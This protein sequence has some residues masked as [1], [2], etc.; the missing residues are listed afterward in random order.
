MKRNVEQVWV[1]R[2]TLGA[3]YK[4]GALYLSKNTVFSPV[5]FL[6]VYSEYEGNIFPHNCCKFV[7]KC[8]ASHTRKL[9]SSE[10]TL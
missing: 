6:F 2:Y 9:Q 1:A 7:P 5:S 8:T 10:S 4:L 3:R